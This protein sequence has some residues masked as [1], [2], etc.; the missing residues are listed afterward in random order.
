[1]E[2]YID[3]RL[4]EEVRKYPHLYN[5]GMKKYKYIYMGFNSWR[6]NA[7]TR[8]RGVRPGEVL[9]FGTKRMRR[10]S[11]YAYESNEVYFA[12]LCV[13]LYANVLVKKEV[14]FGL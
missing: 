4:C 5:C 13:Q 2:A 10:T 12:R 6:E 9:K 1:M 8:K 3:E 7:Q 11:V 14:Y